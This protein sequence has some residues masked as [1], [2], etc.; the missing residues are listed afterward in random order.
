MFAS[1]WGTVYH[2][3]YVL[4]IGGFWSK[5]LFSP[6]LGKQKLWIDLA[7]YNRICAHYSCTLLQGD[8]PMINYLTYLHLENYP[9]E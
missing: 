6:L 1:D 2:D 5:V 4:M 3:N 9:A 7:C 8:R